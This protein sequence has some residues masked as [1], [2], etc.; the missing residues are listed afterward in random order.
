LG[1]HGQRDVAVPAGEGSALKV[2]DAE[3]GFQFAVVVFD[4]PAD[5]PQAYQGFQ[6]GVPAEVG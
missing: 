6:R 5:F 1:E 2:V 3:A 4:A